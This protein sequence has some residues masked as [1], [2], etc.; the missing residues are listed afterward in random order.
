MDNLIEKASYIDVIVM[1]DRIWVKENIIQYKENS[2][3]P[4]KCYCNCHH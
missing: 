1:S 4:L 3:C 2:K